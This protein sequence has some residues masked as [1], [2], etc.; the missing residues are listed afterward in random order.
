MG[1]THLA[2]AQGLAKSLAPQFLVRL[3]QFFSAR[4]RRNRAPGRAPVSLAGCF[5]YAEYLRLNCLENTTTT[6]LRER[7]STGRDAMQRRRPKSDGSRFALLF[8]RVR[9]GSAEDNPL[10]VGPIGTEEGAPG[11]GDAPLSFTL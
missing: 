1:R 6:S 11:D 4:G 7:G 9:N 5:F 2:H 8:T 3:P 10:A